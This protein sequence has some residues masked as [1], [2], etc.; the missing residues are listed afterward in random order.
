M[1]P[2]NDFPTREEFNHLKVVAEENNH[3]LKQMRFWGRVAFWFKVVLWALV[4]VGIPF[5][6]SLSPLA[7]SLFQGVTSSSGSSTS[8]F[9]YPSPTEV[10]HALGH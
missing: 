5:L 7:S 2:Q 6:I 3:I 1:P 10:K 4:L 9:G 8:L